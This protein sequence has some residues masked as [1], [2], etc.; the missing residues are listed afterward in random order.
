MFGILDNM[1]S[2]EKNR[3][4]CEREKQQRWSF[5]ED[6]EALVKMM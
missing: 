6:T 4:I 1:H 3:V 2:I 5:Q